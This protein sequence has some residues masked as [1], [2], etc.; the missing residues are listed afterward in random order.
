[1]ILYTEGSTEAQASEAE[2]V[3][4]I[5]CTA[6]PGHPWAVRVDKGIIFIRHLQMSGKWGMN[7]KTHQVD[8][9]AA[10]LRKKIVMLAGEFLERAGLVRGRED[11]SEVVRVE[12]I[13][14]HDQPYSSKSPVQFST[15]V[16]A[17]EYT[18]LR[19]EARP[20]ALKEEK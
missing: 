6:Y 16:N 4:H 8:H 1:M 12:G 5:L 19:T 14:E 17:S 18:P 15:V 13:P 7:L 3:M 2:K 9:D 20:Q 11:G 10:V